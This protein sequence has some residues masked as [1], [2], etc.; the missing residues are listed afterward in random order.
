MEIIAYYRV[1]TKM[2]GQSGLGIEAQQSSVQAWASA[3]GHTIL[4]EFI[5]HE[6]GAHN[7][8]PQLR[9]AMQCASKTGATLVIAKLDRL[10]RSALFLMQI[11]EQVKAG[12]LKVQALDVPEFNTLSVG[13]LATMAQWERERISER[14]KQALQAKKARGEKLGQ[15]FTPESRA[16]GHETH[17]NNSRN[18][19]SNK[20]AWALVQLM[21]A[22][23]TLVEI[24]NKLNE[25][26][27]TTARG[28]QWQGCQVARLRK[29]MQG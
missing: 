14:T 18:N 12:R 25:N 11:N 23:A 22:T 26:G 9:H 1:S 15:T 19:P 27:Y 24:A 17:R 28:G 13:I 6:S 20:R 10:S 5:E 21:P 16:K 4:S 8:R 29:L 7:D 2:Q 3:G